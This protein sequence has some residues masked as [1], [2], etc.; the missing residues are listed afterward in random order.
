[1]LYVWVKKTR[2]PDLGNV[3][4]PQ[5]IIVIFLAQHIPWVLH[6]EFGGRVPVSFLA[7]QGCV[8]KGDPLRLRLHDHPLLWTRLQL[9][10]RR[11]VV[12]AEISV[13][14]LFGKQNWLRETGKQSVNLWVDSSAFHTWIPSAN[15]R[16]NLRFLQLATFTTEIPLA[17]IFSS[18]LSPKS[19]LRAKAKLLI[20]VFAGL[21]LMACPSLLC[22]SI[23]LLLGPM[24]PGQAPGK[25]RHLR[26]SHI[27]KAEEGNAQWGSSST[28]STPTSATHMIFLYLGAKHTKLSAG[29]PSTRV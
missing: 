7:A 18:S 20:G 4:L 10:R 12:L 26:F 14:Y 28:G 19:E 15:D 24:G 5:H 29:L 1:M 6:F 9:R 2:Q 8:P 27:Q 17:D 25:V 23:V 21:C 3:E 13:L 22:P 11:E 16:N